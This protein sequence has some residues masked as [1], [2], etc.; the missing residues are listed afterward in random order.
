[1]SNW[2]ERGSAGEEFFRALFL[3]KTKGMCSLSMVTGSSN[4]GDG[5]YMSY[6]DVCQPACTTGTPTYKTGHTLIRCSDYVFYRDADHGDDFDRGSSIPL[7]QVPNFF[8]CSSGSKKSQK[9][10]DG[11][12]GKKIFFVFEFSSHTKAANTFPFCF[13]FFVSFFETYFF[14]NAF[15]K[16]TKVFLF[17]AQFFFYIFSH[18]L[19]LVF[20]YY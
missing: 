3:W 11:N 4:C 7:F 5:G 2:G 19:F 1:M 13:T 18:T 15:A 10:I 17:F 20:F 12:A 14:F 16:T 9:N 8:T 6:G